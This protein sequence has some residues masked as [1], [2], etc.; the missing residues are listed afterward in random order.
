MSVLLFSSGEGSSVTK[1]FAIQCA[2]WT[3]SKLQCSYRVMLTRAKLGRMSKATWKFFVQIF[4]RSRNWNTALGAGRRW[5]KLP[6]AVRAV[7]VRTEPEQRLKKFLI[8][9][10]GNRVRVPDRHHSFRVSTQQISTRPKGKFQNR[11]AW[12]ITYHQSRSHF[13]LRHITE[14][15][16]WKVENKAD[17]RVQVKVDA[18]VGGNVPLQWK[19]NIS[20]LSQVPAQDFWILHTHN[21]GHRS[22]YLFLHGNNM[23]I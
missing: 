18:L 3:R 20:R 23:Q 9:T 15:S 16:V 12:R 6:D 19:Q 2:A 21:P 8:T 1:V 17:L 22:I 7:P 11:L 5:T 10:G 4:W 13:R 14:K